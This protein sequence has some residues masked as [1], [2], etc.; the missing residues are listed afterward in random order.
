MDTRKIGV[1]LLGIIVLFVI[2]VVFKAAEIVLVPLIIAG[3]LYFVFAP[4]VNF[5]EQIRIPRA[6]S[7][8]IV[9][10]ILL[11]FFYFIGFLVQT[12]IHSFIKV[13]PRFQVRLA[14]LIR[15]A[16]SL[17][18]TPFG[19]AR[20]IVPDINWMMTLRTTLLSLSGSFLK[21]AGG[22]GIILVFLIFLLLERPYF[23][24]KLI[25]AFDDTTRRKVGEIL[26]HINIQVGRYLAVKL[27]IS[28]ITGLEVYLAL[29]FL[30]IDFPILWGVVAVLVNFIPNLGALFV[31]VVTTLMSL[32]QF[33][34]AFDLPIVTFVVMS[35]IQV[36]MGNFIDPRLLGS[37]LNLS[38]FIILVS[39]IFWGWLWGIVGAFLSVPITVVIKIICDNVPYLRPIGIFMGSGKMHQPKTKEREQTKTM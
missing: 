15:D 37:R 10:L 20:G 30:H 7:I 39:L 24:S 14:L 18:N 36:V 35:L 28:V 5:L 29:L 38:P 1:V 16:Q 4:V 19:D 34:P 6:I 3:L 11:G 13:Y 27:F 32:V 2:G 17:L 23:Q 31:I 26:D 8:I 22:V 9:V 25:N 21:F 33:Y 12:G